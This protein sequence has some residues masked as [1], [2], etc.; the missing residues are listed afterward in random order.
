MQRIFDGLNCGTRTL[1][2]SI[3]D[4]DSMAELAMAGLD[5]YTFSP[6]IA[7]AFFAEPLTDAAAAAFEE[8]AASGQ[9]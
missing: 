3:R 7:R 1:V 4:V 2:A 6:D 9:G 8:A 5:T